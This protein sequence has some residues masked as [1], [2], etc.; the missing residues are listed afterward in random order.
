MFFSLLKKT[1]T[2]E[3]LTEIF[4]KEK[5]LQKNSKKKQSMRKKMLESGDGSGM[6]ISSEGTTVDKTR[7]DVFSRLGVAQ[8]QSWCP[9]VK[10]GANSTNTNIPSQLGMASQTQ[11]QSAEVEGEQTT[12]TNVFSRLGIRREMQ[13][14]EV[15][16]G[17]DQSGV[18]VQGAW[19]TEGEDVKGMWQVDQSEV[20]VQGVWQT[21]GDVKG[22]WQEEGEGESM[23]V[24]NIAKGEGCGALKGIEDIWEQEK[25]AALEFDNA[26]DSG[27][28]FAVH[29]SIH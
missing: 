28:D 13:S 4:R 21:E 23:E 18:R 24:D 2:R 5:Q 16:E 26:S 25:A 1:A 7:T 17:E 22:A 12:R 20:R 6:E 10:G 3:Q 14:P 19:Q 11:G 29:L 8:T 27:V 15:K 9:E